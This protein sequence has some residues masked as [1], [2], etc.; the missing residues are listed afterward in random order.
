MAVLGLL[1]ELEVGRP[2]DDDRVCTDLRGMRC[3]RDGVRRRLRTAVDGNL[4]P[5]IRRL[6]EEVGDEASLLHAQQ[7]PLA[8]RPEREHPV[9]PLAHVEV[10]E[11]LE[12]VVV[13][14]GAVLAEWRDRGGKGSLEHGSTLWGRARG[15]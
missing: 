1:V 5:A 13:D 2:D 10:D 6:Q 14:S 15:V 7:N 9:E 4:Q 11:W 12:R 3:Q 8:R